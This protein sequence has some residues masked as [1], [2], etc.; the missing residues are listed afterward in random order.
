[1]TKP[2]FTVTLSSRVSARIFSA[3]RIY[4]PMRIA[5]R[6][7]NHAWRNPKQEEL[8]AIARPFYTQNLGTII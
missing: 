2:F 4:L 3:Q 6:K 7:A 1:V 8:K 5:I